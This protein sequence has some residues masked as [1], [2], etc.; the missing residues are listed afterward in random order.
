MQLPCQIVLHVQL[1][2][3]LHHQVRLAAIVASRVIF[4]M[5]LV[6]CNVSSANQAPILIH[7]P[8]LR[9]LL[10]QQVPSLRWLLRRVAQYVKN[11]LKA[12]TKML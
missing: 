4:L 11:V 6:H 3:T 7:N 1:V 5:L 2:L 10:V 9:A 12:H 8:L